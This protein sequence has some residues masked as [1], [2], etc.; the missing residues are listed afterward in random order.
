[1]RPK[2]KIQDENNSLSR[3]RED[4]VGDLIF[5]EPDPESSFH[6]ESCAFLQPLNQLLL[7]CTLTRDH[8]GLQVSNQP[9]FPQNQTPPCH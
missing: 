7:I 6:I 1:M 2:K 5:P 9:Q 3:N 4:E 8:P